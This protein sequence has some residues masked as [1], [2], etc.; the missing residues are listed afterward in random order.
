MHMEDRG[1]PHTL[2]L[3]PHPW[4]VTVC[5]NL[6]FETGSLIEVGLIWEARLSA[7]KH[8]DLPAFPSQELRFYAHTI[9]HHT[10]LFWGVGAWVL[11]VKFRSLYLH[12]KHFFD[13][14][15]ASDPLKLILLGLDLR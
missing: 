8:T 13:R 10:Q 1:Q 7:H 2:V 9:T 12:V 11:G 4:F 3:R 5:F 14:T 6:D 15:A